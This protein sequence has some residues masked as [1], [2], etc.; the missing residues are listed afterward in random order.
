[1]GAFITILNRRN[2]V[3]CVQQAYANRNWTTP[4]G[5]IQDGEDPFEAVLRETREEV[6]IDITNLIFSGLYW[7]SYARD[8]VFSFVASSDPDQFHFK[9]NS[10]ISQAAYFDINALPS[11]MAMNTQVRIRDAALRTTPQLTIFHA[12][13][14]YSRALGTDAPAATSEVDKSR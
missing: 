8:L 7:K 9:S 2:E 12:P 5:Q 6:G 10:E 4:G 14:R 13:D 1:M 3:L 11:P